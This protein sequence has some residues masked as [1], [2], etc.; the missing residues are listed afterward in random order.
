MIR[1]EINSDGDSKP[2]IEFTQVKTNK[3]MSIPLDKKIIKIMEK[4]DGEFPRKIS[5]QKYNNY[6]K[7]FVEKLELLKWL[8][9]QD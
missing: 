6:I 5:D 8:M 3:I 9:E 4:Y 7:R 2:L 1:Y